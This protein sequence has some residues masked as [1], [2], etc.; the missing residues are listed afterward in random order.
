MT[1]LYSKSNRGS[2]ILKLK[3]YDLEFITRNI[4]NPDAERGFLREYRC[5]GIWDGDHLQTLADVEVAIDNS[6]L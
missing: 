6:V 1:D 4:P 2:V 5:V 3:D